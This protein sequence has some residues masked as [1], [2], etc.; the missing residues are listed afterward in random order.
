MGLLNQSHT[1]RPPRPNG[2]L[3]LQPGHA[4]R[5]NQ[6]EHPLQD[7]AEANEHNEQLKLS[8][9]R[10]RGSASTPMDNPGTKSTF[11]AFLLV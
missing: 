7:R 9:I 3:A 6:R 11:A 1:E 5:L 8:N 4:R 2:N 10:F